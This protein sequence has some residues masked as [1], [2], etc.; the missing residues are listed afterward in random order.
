ME[1]IV[2]GLLSQNKNNLKPKQKRTHRGCAFSWRKDLH[3]FLFRRENATLHDISGRSSQWYIVEMAHI[4]YN[5]QASCIMIFK[6]FDVSQDRGGGFQ[7][8][9][10]VC[11]S[12][13]LHSF[14]CY[15]NKKR[16]CVA[17]FMHK[18]HKIQIPMTIACAEDAK[19]MLPIKRIY[20][21]FDEI[22]KLP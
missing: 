12:F 9:F 15:L 7:C 4:R 2:G 8:T 3:N 5:L 13:F 10:L 20:F 6:L 21:R 18:L 22:E 14:C 1:T 16:V 11:V 19:H 17:S